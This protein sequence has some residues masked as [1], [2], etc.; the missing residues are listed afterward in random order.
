MEGNITRQKDALEKAKEAAANKDASGFLGYLYESR[1]MDGAKLRLKAI[2]KTFDDER[3]HEILTSAADKFYNAISEGKKIL[4]PASYLWKIIENLARD[5]FRV[6][7]KYVYLDE[8]R[9]GQ[10]QTAGSRKEHVRALDYQSEEDRK[11]RVKKGIEIARLL[12]PKIGSPNVQQVMAYYADAVEAGAE[13]V[14]T[15][16]VSEA[17]GMT[18]SSVRKWK[19]RGFERLRRAAIES[20]YGSGYLGEISGHEDV[21]GPDPE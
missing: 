3:M 7:E 12:L 17:L 16:E 8:E 4:F 18:E 1:F 2:Y 11:E 14:T 10:G 19:Q 13:D 21:N 6:E 5:V 20:G 9:Q 15:K